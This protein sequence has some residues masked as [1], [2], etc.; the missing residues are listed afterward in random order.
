MTSRNS[1]IAL[2]EA[3]SKNRSSEACFG[4]RQDTWIL[5]AYRIPRSERNTQHNPE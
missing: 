2:L 3:V 1:F 5:S 4:F